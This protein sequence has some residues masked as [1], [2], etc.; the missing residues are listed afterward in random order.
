M[1]KI[2]IITDSDTAVRNNS[3]IVVTV[4][5]MQYLTIIHAKLGV[6]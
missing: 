4:Y 2:K 1:Y 6:A 3:K 5:E